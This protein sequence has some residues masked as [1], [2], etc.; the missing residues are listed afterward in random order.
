M[1]RAASAMGLHALAGLLTI[2]VTVLIVAA[3]L[4]LLFAVLIHPTGRGIGQ[5]ATWARIVAILISTG[6]ALA[7]GTIMAVMRRDHAPIMTLPI[8]LSLYSLW[9][10]IWRF[11]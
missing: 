7:S 6:L 8:S 9:V 11:D 1:R 10:L 4:T 3:A 5:H 2:L